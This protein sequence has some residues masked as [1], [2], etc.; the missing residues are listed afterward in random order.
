MMAHSVANEKCSPEERKTTISTFV[1]LDLESTGL[2]GNGKQPRITELS[3][4]AVH[5]DN[6][7]DPCKDDTPRVLNKLTLCTYPMKVVEHA[8]GQITGETFSLLKFRG[9]RCDTQ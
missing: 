9:I 5:R 1:F 2:G 8:A 4:I 3:L 7:Q 6:L